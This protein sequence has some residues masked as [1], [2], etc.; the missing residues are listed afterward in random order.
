MP[1]LHHAELIEGVV[2]MPSPVSNEDHG[3]PHFQL[4]GWLWFYQAHTPGV[5]GGDNSTLRLDLTNAPQPDGFLRILPASG[6]QSQDS[7]DGKYIEGAPELIA[8]IAASSASYDLHDKMNAYRRNDV[9]EYLVWR[10]WD[11]E[12]D[13][14]VLRGGRYEKQEPEDDGILKSEV[15][16]GL[17]LDVAALLSGNQRRLLEV[18]QAGIAT[19]QHAEFVERL[20]RQ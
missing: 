4:N 14:F 11:A 3:V 12:V 20:R 5:E 10:V 8:E 2:Y 19:P 9:R 15:F 16:P 7:A 17:W 18:L 1:N 6:G 13:W